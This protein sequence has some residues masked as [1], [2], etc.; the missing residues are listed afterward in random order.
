MS[1]CLRDHVTRKAYYG[2]IG[3]HALMIFLQPGS[4]GYKFEYYSGGQ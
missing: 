3:K 1:T 4:R 2:N